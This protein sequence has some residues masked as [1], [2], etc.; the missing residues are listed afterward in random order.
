M[1]VP[2]LKRPEMVLPGKN[3]WKTLLSLSRYPIT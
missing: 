2:V 3:D 1:P